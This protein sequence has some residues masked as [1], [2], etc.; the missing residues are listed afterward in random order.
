VAVRVPVVLQIHERDHE[1]QRPLRAS[2]TNLSISGRVDAD[3]R[4]KVCPM[5][6]K[7]PPGDVIYEKDE[8]VIHL[9]D[10]EEHKVS[11]SVATSGVPT[12]SA[13]A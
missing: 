5:Q 4:K 6:E 13:D 2:L 7:P 8:F 3:G 12:V 9:I 1:V 11:P 10:G